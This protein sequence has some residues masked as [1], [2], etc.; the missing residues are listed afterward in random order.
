MHANIAQRSPRAGLTCRPFCSEGGISKLTLPTVR[1]ADLPMICYL[2]AVGQV[3]SQYDYC[4]LFSTSGVFDTPSNTHHDTNLA[5]KPRYIH[6][7][8]ILPRINNMINYRPVDTDPSVRHDK[9]QLV[10]GLLSTDP[11]NRRYT[12][13]CWLPPSWAQVGTE[14][15]DRPL[16]IPGTV[17]AL[18]LGGPYLVHPMTIPNLTCSAHS[19]GH[20]QGRC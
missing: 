18:S 8:L 13:S 4:F 5:A 10:C 16:Q 14:C 15:V 3:E 12:Y 1:I 2:S 6:E 11:W 9:T 19:P 17:C 7:T 20:R